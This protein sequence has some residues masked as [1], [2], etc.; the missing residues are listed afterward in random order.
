LAAEVVGVSKARGVG[1]YGEQVA[2]DHLQARGLRILDRNWRCGSGEIDI[3]AQDGACLVVCE[4]KT[5]R[6]T[7]FGTAAEAVT[8]VKLGRL[9]RLT[10]AWLATHDGHWRDVRIDVVTVTPGVGGPATVEHLKAVG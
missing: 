2:A 9:R 4:V 3:V 6:S 10:A 5:R 7:A 1:M 8:A